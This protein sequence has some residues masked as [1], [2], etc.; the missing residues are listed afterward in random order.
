MTPYFIVGGWHCKGLPLDSHDTRCMQ[1]VTILVGSPNEGMR[2]RPST[3]EQGTTLTC[4]ND[5]FSAGI[6]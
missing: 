1:I 4:F 5:A 6:L 2:K 3:A